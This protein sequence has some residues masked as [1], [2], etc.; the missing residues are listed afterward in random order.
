MKWRASGIR[1]S[2]IRV[3]RG[4]AV[5]ELLKEKVQHMFELF[6][7]ATD[8]EEKDGV[9]SLEEFTSPLSQVCRC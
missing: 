2:G 9:L 8:G 7:C 6:V 4:P 1:A 3:K 5:D